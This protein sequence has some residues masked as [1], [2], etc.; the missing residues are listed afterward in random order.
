M[1]SLS[2]SEVNKGHSITSKSGVK[3][4]RIGLWLRDYVQLWI[5]LNFSR[6]KKLCTQN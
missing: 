2:S 3:S 6:K 5:C 4:G 1:P